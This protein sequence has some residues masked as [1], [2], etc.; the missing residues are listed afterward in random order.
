MNV[1]DGRT[2]C[3]KCASEVAARRLPVNGRAVAASAAG[4]SRG[5]SRDS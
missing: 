1:G 3:P 2:V 5:F 4:P